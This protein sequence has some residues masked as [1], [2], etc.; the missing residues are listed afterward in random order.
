MF[1]LQTQQGIAL[2]QRGW[3]PWWSAYAKRK[4][5]K[6]RLIPFGVREGPNTELTGTNKLTDSKVR[7]PRF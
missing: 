5:K 1:I 2:L 4:H 6:V 3:G 7:L